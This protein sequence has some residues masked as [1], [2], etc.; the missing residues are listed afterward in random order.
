VAHGMTAEAAIAEIRRLRPGSIETAA[1]EQAVRDY[2]ALIA[3][4][5]P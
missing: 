2:A 1:Q 5:T 4:R 3:S